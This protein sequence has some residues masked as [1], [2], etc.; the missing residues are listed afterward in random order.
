VIDSVLMD[1]VVKPG[2]IDTLVGSDWP[3][4]TVSSSVPPLISPVAV[5]TKRIVLFAAAPGTRCVS[6]ASEP[7][8]S[9][10]SSGTARQ[11]S[12][13]AAQA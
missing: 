13:A 5:E 1:A 12:I 9:A 3:C 4:G 7:E 2:G 6:V 8:W 10:A 11:L